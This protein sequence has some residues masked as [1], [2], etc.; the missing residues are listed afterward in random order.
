[1]E[2]ALRV[3][4]ENGL[5]FG[6]AA[7]HYGVPKTTLNNNYKGTY[8]DMLGRPTALSKV[9]EKQITSAV[10]TVANFGYTFVIKR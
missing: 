10:L 2:L 1:M 7:K 6:Q 8:S 3:V 4:V 5:S 9:K